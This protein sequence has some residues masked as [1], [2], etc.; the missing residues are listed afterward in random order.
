MPQSPLS[1]LCS[2]SGHCRHLI[3]SPALDPWL[4]EVEIS[5]M[6]IPENSSVR[7]IAL[8]HF[9]S[10]G[11]I[12]SV[13]LSWNCGERKKESLLRLRGRVLEKEKNERNACFPFSTLAHPPQRQPSAPAVISHRRERGKSLP[14]LICQRPEF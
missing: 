5:V 6:G 13:I 9:L 2:L 10:R 12:I 14:H 3:L 8:S 7:Q 4:K 1:P 11:R